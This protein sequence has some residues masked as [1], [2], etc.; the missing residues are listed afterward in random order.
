MKVAGKLNTLPIPFLVNP[1]NACGNYGFDCPLEADKTYKFKLTLPILRSYPKV[2]VDVF[3]K[4]VD[5]KGQIL[6]CV[7]LPAHIQ[8]PLKP[9]Q[10][11]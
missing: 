2:N 3:L 9:P 11:A 5:G 8:E 10:A 6:G 4:L 7:E 1:D